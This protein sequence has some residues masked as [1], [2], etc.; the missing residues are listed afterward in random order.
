MFGKIISVACQKGGVGKTTSAFYLARILAKQ[1]PH[2]KVCLI[3]ADQQGNSTINF[4][5]SRVEKCTEFYDLI[6]QY[7]PDDS[8]SINI[9]S[10]PLSSGFEENLYVIPT[11]VRSRLSNVVT[12][13]I[14]KDD[15]VGDILHELR[16]KFDYI[17]IDTAPNSSRFEKDILLHSDIIIP[18][19]TPS[20]YSQMGLAQ[21]YYIINQLK[22]KESFKAQTPIIVLNM[23]KK[24]QIIDKESR[25]M[26]LEFCNNQE[27]R[28]FEIPNQEKVNQN[29]KH[30]DKDIDKHPDNK[31]EFYKTFENVAE[32]IGRN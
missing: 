2:S 8:G 28:L 17:I 20:E 9:L 13:L 26:L 24:N 23:F 14:N 5:D 1:N 11:L 12:I 29:G 3:D 18:V 31:T 10:V 21:L 15:I 4:I 27:S 30:I 7:D 25:E 19:V 22:R 32:L 6:N 16:K